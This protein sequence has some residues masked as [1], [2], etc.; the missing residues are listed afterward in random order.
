MALLRSTAR[1][2]MAPSAPSAGS[3]ASS[4]NRITLRLVRPALSEGVGAALGA[5]AGR[6]GWVNTLERLGWA[7][8]G[9][10]AG[11]RGAGCARG[12]GGGG[13]AALAMRTG[14]RGARGTGGGRRIDREAAARAGNQKLGHDAGILPAGIQKDGAASGGDGIDPHFQAGVDALRRAR[15]KG[16]KPKTSRE[17]QKGQGTHDVDSSGKVPKRS[18]AVI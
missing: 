4:A 18:L 5:G 14:G 8:K 1:N 9:L 12:G 11:G 10:D 13:G 16:S 17:A 3:D 7:T 2:L 15:A 6:A